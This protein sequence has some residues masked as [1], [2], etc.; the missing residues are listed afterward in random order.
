MPFYLPTRM[1]M[2]T[3]FSL[4]QSVFSFLFFFFFFSPRVCVSV[5]L[6]VVA[7]GLFFFPLFLCFFSLLAAGSPPKQSL[8]AAR[9]QY[10][11]QPRRLLAMMMSVTA[12]KTTWMLFVSVAHVMWQ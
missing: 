1:I 12:S 6:C 11:P 8:S 2:M 7:L 9:G 3:F 5:C 10:K 4:L